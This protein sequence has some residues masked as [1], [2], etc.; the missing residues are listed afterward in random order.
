MLHL[1]IFTTIVNSSHY[2][3]MGEWMSDTM[4]TLQNIPIFTLLAMAA[5][6]IG[7][8]WTFTHSRA[9]GAHCF[10]PIVQLNLSGVETPRARKNPCS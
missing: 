7:N 8:T 1:C 2:V 3:G 9:V 4:A 6:H 5:L 10:I